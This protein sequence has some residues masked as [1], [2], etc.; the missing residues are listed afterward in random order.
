MA[1]ANIYILLHVESPSATSFRDQS[2]FK[3][4]APL[5]FEE[6]SGAGST[7]PPTSSAEANNTVEELDATAPPDDSV[8]P[9][10]VVVA[11]VESLV[12]G[13]MLY[14]PPRPASASELRAPAC[15]SEPLSEGENQ[16]PANADISQPDSEVGDDLCPNGAIMLSLA[17]KTAFFEV[18]GLLGSRWSSRSRSQQLRRSSWRISRCLRLRPSTQS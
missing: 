16:P 6:A 7:M 10:S 9:S 12:T 4:S 3:C 2:S 8:P 14:E 13:T 11:T 15:A 17:S 1:R 5:S 18:F